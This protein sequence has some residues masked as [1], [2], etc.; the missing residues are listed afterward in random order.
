M[1]FYDFEAQSSRGEKISMADYKGKWLLV[2]NTATK[3]GL[4]PQF[5]G[6]E[7]L[8]KKYG[9]KNLSLLGFPCNQ[10][11]NQ[12]PEGDRESAEVCKVNFGVTFPL[13]KRVNVNGKD[14]H[15]VFKYLKKSLKKGLSSRIKWNFTKFLIDPEGNPVKRFSPTTKPKEIEAYLLEKWS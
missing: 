4:S 1:I 12:N 15:P 2:I 11:L 7:E 5:E 10:F 13:T 9:D 6:L 3:C 14:A 8:H